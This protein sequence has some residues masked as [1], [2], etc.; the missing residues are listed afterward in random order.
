MYTYQP[1]E[2]TS[3]KT[4]YQAFLAAFQG[5]PVTINTS[6]EAFENMLQRRGYL[7]RLSLGAFCR[8]GCQ[9]AGF[10]LN[11]FRSLYGQPTAYDILTATVPAHR[12]QGITSTILER[13]RVLLREHGA[14]QYVTEVLKSNTG[15]FQAYQK[16]GFAVRREL[17]C[18]RLEQ[19]N[20][21]PA[22]PACK[23][24]SLPDLDRKTWDQLETFWDF[25]PTWQNSIDSVQAASGRMVNVLARTGRDIVGY[26]VADRQTGDLPQLAVR[27][28]CRRKGIAGNIVAAL[29][30]E[31]EGNALAML[32][33]DDAH[34]GTKA[35]LSH[36]GFAHTVGQYELA[37]PL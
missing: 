29:F 21:R 33:V 36:S 17:C 7:P 3:T 10:V 20:Y 22:A 9:L 11:G 30:R 5:Y 26:G 24:E 37:L 23:T 34:E 35:F 15:A 14:E 27:S 19:D 8:G 31:V 13:L 16:Q 1:L 18:Y 25:S 2:N 12:R 4:L 28:D 6:L 32:N